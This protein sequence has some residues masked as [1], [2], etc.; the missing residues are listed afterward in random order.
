LVG[1]TVHP[2][3]GP[4][5]PNGTVVMQ[6]GK[7]TAVGASVSIPGGATKVDVKGLHIYP[8]LIDAD[9]TLGVNEIGSRRETQDYREIGDFQ[10]ELQVA[11]TINPD[12][13]TLY[14]ARTAGTLNAVVCPAGG[15][16]S[17]M[18]SLLQLDGWT[19]EDFAIVPNSGVYINFPTLGFRRFGETAHRCEE[20]AGSHDHEAESHP[21]F[22][23]GAL[24]PATSFD[25]KALR[26]GLVPEEDA[27]AQP[28]A[29]GQVPGGGR[30]R[31]IPGQAPGQGGE[32][33][34][35]EREEEAL[36][37]LNNFFDD[38]KA[39]KKAK[40]AQ[41][42]PGIPPLVRDPRLE[43]MIPILE[44]KVPLFIRADR[45]RDIT[46]AVNWAKKEGYKM[47][48][49]GGQEADECAELLAKEKIPVVLGP[50]MNLPRRFDLPYDDAYT[51]PARLAK[52]GVIF[53][54][55][56]GDAQDA[57]RLPQQAAM[58]ASYG[59]GAE[60]ALKAI[61]LYPAQILGAG[62]RLGS[63]EVGK[64]AN[65]LVTT[66]NPLETTSAIKSAYIAGK[67]ISLVNKQTQLYE[68][69]RNRPKK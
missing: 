34:A 62:E 8:G 22:R 42:K 69:W 30:G 60:E 11:L 4:A 33:S 40:E 52:A 46:V 39:Y 66:G 28:P 61:T 21:M 24:I 15:T 64:D 7:I 50:V 65:L 32:Q 14:V 38:A 56:T 36:R 59:L 23:S 25:S 54:L 27:Q 17:G 20:T 44:K 3:S 16:I 13:N 19:Y 5:I 10:P 37:P 26:Y 43:A 48:L 45:K 35:R 67:P 53:C 58:A 55:S 47:V 41:G 9:T 31:G 12:A 1:G 51:L 29:P 68:K 49:L 2:V 57:R 18:G 6:G 63:I